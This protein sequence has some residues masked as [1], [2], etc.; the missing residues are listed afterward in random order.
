MQTTIIQSTAGDRLDLPRRALRQQPVKNHMDTLRHQRSSGV[1]KP[2]EQQA[3]CRLL[4]S[5]G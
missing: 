1:A 2:P 4:D 5:D 3:L